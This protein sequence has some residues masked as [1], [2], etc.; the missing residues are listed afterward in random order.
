MMSCPDVVDA[1]Q[2]DELSIAVT[3]VEETPEA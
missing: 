1:K 2:L 3:R